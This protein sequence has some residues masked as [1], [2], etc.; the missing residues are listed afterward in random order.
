M[1]TAS[2][3]EQLLADLAAEYRPQREWA[4]GRGVFLII[5]HFLVGVAGGAWVYGQ[6]FDVPLCLLAAYVLGALGGL[7][8]L[9]NLARPERFWRMALKVRTSWIARGFWGLGLFMLG[10]LLSLPPLLW[11][12]LAWS[13]ASPVA[14]F[15][16]V[17]GWIGAVVMIC[18]MGF[19]YTASKGIPFWNSPLHPVLYIAYAMRG[20]AAALLTIAA[21]FDLPIDPASGLLQSWMGVTALVLALWVFEISFILSGGDE[22]ARRSVHELLQGRLAI[23]VYVG[24]LLV[25][26]LLPLFLI[27]G[28]A[29]PQTHATLALMGIASIVGDFFMK[30][31]SIKAGVHLPITLGRA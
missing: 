9:F 22:A 20:G 23:Y 8:H 15:G 2:R 6:V 12:G 29:L 1:A 16:T 26:L 19:V 24:I 10:G 28:I 11:P 5:G 31:S 21:L 3:Y 25:G 14:Q 13:A 4:E 18:Y 30:W 27:S 7:A 17:L